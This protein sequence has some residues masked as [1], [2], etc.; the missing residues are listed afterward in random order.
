MEQNQ[1]LPQKKLKKKTKGYKFKSRLI[2]TLP[3]ALAIPLM[4]I[5]TAVIELFAGNINEFGFAFEDFI[6]PMIITALGLFLIITAILLPLRKKAFD[7]AHAVVLWLGAM[8]FLQGNFLNIG[9]DSLAADGV[10]N[11][12]GGSGVIWQIINT[13]LW[14]AS[15]VG[16]IYVAAKGVL[17]RKT[18]KTVSLMTS[19]FLIFISVLSLTVNF[20][21][22]DIMGKGKDDGSGDTGKD[23]VKDILST[24]HLT[25]LSPYGNIIMFVVDRYDGEYFDE[26]YEEEPEFFDNLDGFTYYDNH[27]SL[28]ARTYPSLAYMLTGHENTFQGSRV[29]FFKRVYQNSPFLKDLQANNYSINIYTD[30]WYGFNKASDLSGVADN[31]RSTKGYHINDER[32]LAGSLLEVCLY[33]YFPNILKGTVSSVSSSTFDEYIEYHSEYRSYSTENWAVYPLVKDGK[34]HISDRFEDGEKLF[35]CIHLAG[36]HM[37]CFYDE[38]ANKTKECYDVKVA[39]KGSFIII[40]EY[41]DRMRELG[42]Y[43]DSTIIIVG[44]HADPLN[45]YADVYRARTTSLFVKKKGESGTP[46]KFNSA[47]VAHENLHATIVKSEGINTERD[48]GI[49]VFD[50]PLDSDHKRKYIFQKSVD[51]GG[52][53][54]DRLV[55]YSI[56]G[57]ARNLKNWKK[58]YESIIG[59]FY[60]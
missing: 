2:M 27:I 56:S 32:A 58:E 33:R 52:K 1:K 10:G 13:V 35:S 19:A 57:D 31:V 42:I 40:N 14:L 60:K 29:N 49:A 39:Q 23:E 59:Y 43:E 12:E 20:T 54:K 4:I 3:L 9:L 46:F 53:R 55:F 41:L 18:V 11:T 6:K 7:I 26:L 25:E 36:C 16:I 37:P 22:V 21:T 48:Y 45:D 15:G 50:M 28:Y 8:L 5:V 47:P 24:E 38:E 51:E 34:V 30:D 17:K 44:D